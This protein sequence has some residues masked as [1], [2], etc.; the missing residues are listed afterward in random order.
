MR[1]SSRSFVIVFLPLLLQPI[2]AAENWQAARTEF[3]HP[4][5][6]GVWFYGSATPMERPPNL[7]AQLIY[8]EAEA[9]ELNQ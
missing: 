5:L 7:G 4:D 2:N 6:Q 9:I 1:F 8:S 3:G